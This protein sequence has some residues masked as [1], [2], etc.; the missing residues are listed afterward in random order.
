MYGPLVEPR[1]GDRWMQLVGMCVAMMAI[2]NLQYAWT[3]FTSPLT[4][5][6]G[7]SLAVV[8]VAF[9]AFV[10]AETWLVP[11]EALLI[12]RFGPRLVLCAG[13]LLVGLGWIGSGALAPGVQWVWVW[14]TIGGLGAGAVYGGCIG[15]AMKWFPDRRGLAA[16]LVA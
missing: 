6:Y 3:L 2:A 13:G 5:Q 7:V 4:K 10:L 11:F 14:Y 15:V 12:D 8:Q 9:S 16:G 1:A